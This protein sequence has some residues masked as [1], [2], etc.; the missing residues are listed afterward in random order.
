MAQT[1]EELV[2]VDRV[3]LDLLL[4]VATL[5]VKSFAPDE[6]VTLPEKLNI[7]YV[8]EILERYGRRY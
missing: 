6:F 1:E 7:Q 2:V 8:E 3:S 4:A 5:Y